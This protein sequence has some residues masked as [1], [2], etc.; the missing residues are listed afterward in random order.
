MSAIFISHSNKDNVAAANLKQQLTRKGYQSVFLDFDP[1]D[2]IPP[3]RDWERE[4]YQQLRS[5]QAVIVLCSKHS[6][7][8]PWCFAEITHAKALG[9][10]IFPIKVTPCRIITILTGSQ[11]LDFTRNK[12]ECYERLWRGLKT[13]GLDP[14]SAYDWDTRRCPYPGL[15][16]FQEVDAPVFFGR[17]EDIHRGL[18]LLNRLRQFGGTRSIMILGPSGSGKSSLVRAGLLPRL[19]MNPDQWLV[20]EPFRPREHPFQEFA[21]ALANTFRQAG[22]TRN[23]QDIRIELEKAAATEMAATSTAWRKKESLLCTA[24]LVYHSFIRSDHPT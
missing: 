4:L 17:D 3:G 10:P 23:W 7:A 9:K 1:Q 14:T 6:M 18:E 15:M 22:E 12:K 8:S 16:S 5:C 21:I 11:F 13:A 19:R 20:I 24:L 2:G